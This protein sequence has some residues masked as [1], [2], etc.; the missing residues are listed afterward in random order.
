MVVKTSYNSSINGNEM[1]ASNKRGIR[2]L[3]YI[4]IP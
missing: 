2:G 1:M 4:D 3:Q